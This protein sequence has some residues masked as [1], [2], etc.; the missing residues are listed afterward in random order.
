MFYSTEIL[1]SLALIGLSFVSDFIAPEKGLS[2]AKTNYIFFLIYSGI[3][4]SKISRIFSRILNEMQQ[5][6]AV[7]GVMSNL[8]PFLRDLLGMLVCIF[9][10]FGQLGINFFGGLINSQ[11][12]NVHQIKTGKA[13]ATDYQKINFNDFPN[14]IVTLW[15]LFLRNKWLETVNMYLIMMP[16]NRFRWFFVAFAIITN[17]LI[18]NLIVGFV[19]EVIL[20]HL[21]KKYTK[22]IKI[23][24]EMLR[25]IVNEE[26]FDDSSEE[27]DKEEDVYV[28]DEKQMDLE[29]RARLLAEAINK[30]LEKN[31]ASLG[32]KEEK[33]DEKTEM[34]NEMMPMI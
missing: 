14:A 25:G 31:L 24:E 11:T 8:K 16:T 4:F 21:N 13:L 20:T 10:I 26:E 18:M 1:S 28:D 23:D 17:F 22:F 2:F 6:K 12:P 27:S 29:E 15:N 33:L 32:L 30:G 7:F 5:V 34:H 19:V 3:C 9:L